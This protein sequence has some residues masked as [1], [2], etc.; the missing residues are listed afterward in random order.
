MVFEIR[1]SLF[2]IS[3]AIRNWK[4]GVIARVGNI[5]VWFDL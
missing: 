4:I 1:I 5:G 3:T 2:E